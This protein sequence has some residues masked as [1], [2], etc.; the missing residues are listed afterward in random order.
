MHN[1]FVGFAEV[2]YRGM[3]INDIAIL[4]THAGDKHL[5]L[6]HFKVTNSEGEEV[7]KLFIYPQKEEMQKLRKLVIDSYL[8]LVR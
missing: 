1:G 2:C 3:K 8:T 4:E 7:K 5:V 6:P